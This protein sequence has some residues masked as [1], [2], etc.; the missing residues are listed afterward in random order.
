MSNTVRFPASS[1]A[2][3]EAAKRMWER[4]Y[5]GSTITIEEENGTFWVTRTTG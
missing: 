3:A 5:P 4:F 2:E 1:Q